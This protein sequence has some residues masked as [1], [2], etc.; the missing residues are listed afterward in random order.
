VLI[1]GV[2]TVFLA[3][4]NGKPVDKEVQPVTEPKENLKTDSSIGLGYGFGLHYPLYA[5]GGLGYWGIPYGYGYGHGLYGYGHG[6]Y[7]YYPHY[8]PHYWW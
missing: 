3:A 2:A 5:H 7:G 4:V 6:L 1:I 8:Y